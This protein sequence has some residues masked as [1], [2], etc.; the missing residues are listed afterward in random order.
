MAT[1]IVHV[2][3]PTLSITNDAVNYLWDSTAPIGVAPGASYTNYGHGLTAQKSTTL[4]PLRRQYPDLIAIQVQ[5]SCTTQNVTLYYATAL[6]SATT[7]TI[8]NGSGSGQTVT[9]G[10]PLEETFDCW[11]IESR[12]Y[13]TNGATGPD[14]LAA[15]LKLIIGDRGGA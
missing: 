11:G 6:Q 4:G 7:W 1:E 13:I 12:V 10:T 15:S 14:A 2:K 8:W 5:V 9:A 3:L